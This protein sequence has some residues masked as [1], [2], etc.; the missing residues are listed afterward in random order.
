MLAEQPVI[1]AQA[2]TYATKLKDW[3]VELDVNATQTAIERAWARVPLW[4]RI[5]G[6]P[7]LQVDLQWAVLPELFQARLE[8][9]RFLE[10]PPQEARVRFE[11]GQVQVIPHRD[12]LRLD[13]N[14]SARNLLTALRNLP[15]PYTR[16]ELGFTPVVPRIRTEQLHSIQGVISSYT[17]RFP[18]GQRLR[19]HNIRLAANAL[20]GVIL[21]PGERLSYNQVV[22]KRTVKRGFRL[23]PVIIYGEK[24]LGVGGGVCQVSSTLFNAALLSGLAILRRA[25]HSIPVDYVP[26][27]RDA[28][29]AD[30]V[31]DLVIANPFDHPIA[32]T[33]EVKRSSLTI[34]ILGKPQPGRQIVLKTE[35]RVLPVPPIKRVP[36]PRLPIGTQRVLKKGAAGYRVVLWR[37]V[38]ENGRLIARERVATSIYR[39]QPRVIAVGTKPRTPTPTRLR[40]DSALTP[41]VFQTPEP[42][43]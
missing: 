41:A 8:Q 9:F 21:L 3:G 23:A 16:F 22:G 11:Q 13:W 4:Q 14:A 25:N 1:V 43:P 33:T 42:A 6:R 29:V 15:A 24:R 19:N 39:A 30:G 38:Y 10:R 26:L 35:R 28:T 20:N 34:R 17:T 12:G 18:S 36:D 37:E 5:F 27:G 31:A 32:I 40:G 7:R 2:P